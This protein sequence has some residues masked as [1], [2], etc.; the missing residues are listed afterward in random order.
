M[1]VSYATRASSVSSHEDACVDPTSSPS[2]SAPAAC[3]VYLCLL[4]VCV[5]LFCARACILCLHEHAGTCTLPCLCAEDRM[6]AY[7]L[8][9]LRAPMSALLLQS[10]CMPSPTLNAREV[11][12]SQCQ[13]DKPFRGS[14]RE[15][16]KANVSAPT[17]PAKPSR[18]QRSCQRA[19]SPL[20]APAHVRV[21]EVRVFV[22]VV[23]VRVRASLC[24]CKYVCS[25]MCAYVCT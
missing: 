25:C 22:R 9:Y 19:T 15:R 18:V 7:Q 20:S 6:Q 24:A 16:R 17:N 12:R 11:D 21:D 13:Q 8:P 23:R 2:C 3:R 1:S 10:N 14:T 5:L 4:H